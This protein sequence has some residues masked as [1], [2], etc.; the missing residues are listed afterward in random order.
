MKLAEALV[1]RKHLESKVKQLE[2]IYINGQKGV[3]ETKV[4]RR[5][6]DAQN[7]VDEITATVPK[8]TLEEVT[9][10]YD[11]YSKALRELDTAIQHTNW[12]TELQ[13]SVE[14]KDIKV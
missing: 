4:E 2:P 10:E 12:T 1:L 6:V 5:A 3:F 7:G 13:G 14:L 8:V 11:K 9:G